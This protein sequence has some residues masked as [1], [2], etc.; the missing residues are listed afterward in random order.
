MRLFALASLS[1]AVSSLALHTTAQQEP[2]QPSRTDAA[3]QAA[4]KAIHAKTAYRDFLNA[5]QA[6]GG[7]WTAQWHPA[8]VTPSAIYGTGLRIADWRENTLVEARRHALAALNTYHDMLGLGTSEFREIIGARMGRT[9]SF[10]FDQFFNGLPV[11]EGRADVR[12]NMSGVIAMLGS[13][14]WPIPANFNT[15]PA[16]AQQVAEAIAWN[17]A[18]TPTGAPQ[19]AVA[20]PRL[21]I[22]GDINAADEAPFFLAWEIPVSNVDRN[23]QGPIG[24]YYVDAQTGAVLRYENDKHE[25]GMPNCMNS[26]HGVN[27]RELAGPPSEALLPVPTIVTVSAWTRTGNDAY[28]AL[29]NTPLQGV[30]VNVPGV[31]TRTTDQNGEFTIDIAAPVTVSLTSLDGTH[32]APITGANAPSASVTVQPGVNATLQLLTAAATTNEAAHTTTAYWVDR[33]NEWVR[34]ILDMNV[35]SNQSAMN[36]ISGISPRVNIA[37]TCNAYYTNNT[38]NFYNAGGN[39]AN[40]AFSTVISHEWGHGL[41]DRFGGISNS[42]GDGLSE[43]WGDIIGMY[44]VDSPNLGQGFQT[45]GVALR[46][47]NNTKMYGSQTEVHAAGEIW[48]GFAWRLRQNLRNT[49]G[50]P[51]AVAISDDIVISSIVAD[52]TNQADAVREVFIADDDDGNLANGVPH[53]NELSAAAIAKGMP[54]PVIQI[55]SIQH[56]ALGNTSARLVPRKVAAFAAAV[57]SGSIT[58]VRLHYDAGNGPQVRNMKPNG[59]VNGYEAV[60]PAIMSGSISYH[61]EADHSSNVT[62][63]SPESGEYSYV[64][65]VAPTGPFVGFWSENFDGALSGWTS[66]QVLAQNDWQV[67][68]PNGR[69]GTSQSVFWADPQNAYS[70][71]NVYG[72]DLGNTI[73]TTNWNGAYAANVENYLRSPVI[74]CSGR[75]GMTLRFKRWLT[76]EEGIYDQATLFVNGIQVWQNPQNGHLVDTSWQS[77]EYAIPMADNNP[78]VQIEWRLKSDGGLQLGGWNIDDVELGTRYTAPLEATLMMTPE[79]AAQTTPINIAIHT[80]GPTTI[81]ALAIGDT[82]GPTLIPNVPPVFVGGNYFVLGDVSNASGDFTASFGAPLINTTVGLTWFSQVVT[83]DATY[84]NLITSNQWFNLFTQTP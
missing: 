74:N 68:D 72:N 2:T 50:T 51:Q 27:R 7:R 15:N 20:Q 78:V 75:T 55:A 28:S 16:V 38:I 18:G 49:Y 5:E 46:S 35:P 9:W 19:P 23:G 67:G 11:I 3:Q 31:G 21:V 76:V 47:G 52:A 8:T 58:A 29:V 24:R 30:V 71:T 25:C 60:L 4:A 41:D 36:T 33:T 82:S 83:F 43:G 56:T 80:P 54:Y 79:Q 63:R 81:F 40:T 64:V 22:W 13:R 77:V 17:R 66:A 42:S 61:I 65:S 53:Y 45:Q 59:F 26:H 44:L 69:S 57:T 32:Y 14:A 12:I 34:S 6:N 70:G 73:G 37:S 1:L 39:C 10:T 48:M 62:V 84:T